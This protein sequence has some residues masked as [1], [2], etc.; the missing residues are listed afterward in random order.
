MPFKP[1][2]EVRV[3]HPFYETGLCA[4][5]RIV[6]SAAASAR[7]QACRLLTRT[8]P[9]RLVLVADFTQ[10][11]ETR[12]ALPDALL[13]CSVELE[14]S[15]LAATDL[16]SL[17]EG[18]LFTDAGAGKPMKA[19]VPEVRSAE[20]LA[21]PDGNSAIVLSGRPK[22]GAKAAD[23]GV[24][25]PSSVSVKGYDPGSGSVTLAGPAAAVTLDYPVAPRTVP[26]AIAEVEVAIS[27]A[28]AAKA[29]A[30]KP[31][32]LRVVLAAA[33]APWCYHLVT[34]LPNPLAEWKIAHAPADG[35]AADFGAA[36]SAEIKA[37][38][39]TDPFGSD[40]LARSAPLR[41]LRFV[42]DQAVPCTEKRARR[43]SLSAGDRQLFPALPNPSPAGVRLLKG[44][45][46]FGETLRFVTA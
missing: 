40:L 33:A 7:I 24:I 30:G 31:A 42:S 14:P 20:Q 16:S 15:I 39:P 36:G 27:A 35:P 8:S 46:A 22:A 3:E 21:K 38:D 11:G 41:V 26:G 19:T 6:P 45:P 13:R 18:S 34:D 5:A 17:P 9:G 25:E 28:L 10:S 44:K 2:L 29:A 4:G 23:F 32:S 43:M 12:V 37:A 1:L